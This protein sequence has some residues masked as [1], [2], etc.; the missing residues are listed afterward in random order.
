MN[1]GWNSFLS[2]QLPVKRGVLFGRGIPDPPPPENRDPLVPVVSKWRWRVG[3]SPTSTKLFWGIIA[4]GGAFETYCMLSSHP[5]AFRIWS[6]LRYIILWEGLLPWKIHRFCYDNDVSEP[7]MDPPSKRGI[8][9]FHPNFWRCIHVARKQME[10]Q[11][12]T[13]TTR[14]KVPG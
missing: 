13:K 10:K 9:E 14:V 5:R 7:E 2:V 6:G 8:F 3:C 1:H 12:L 4:A 11:P